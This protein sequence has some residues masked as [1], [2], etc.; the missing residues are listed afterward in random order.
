MAG[1]LRVMSLLKALPI[2]ALL[3]CPL[4]VTAEEPA[5]AAVA[6]TTEATTTEVP[7]EAIMAVITTAISEGVP[8]FND[9]DHQGCADR[10][11]AG[12]ERLAGFGAEA[13][14]PWHHHQVT[15][16]L[17]D[18]EASATDRAWQIRRVF[19]AI[20]LDLQFV[21]R[22]EASLPEGFPEPGPVGQVVRKDYPSYRMAT[23]EGRA[24][25]WTLFRHIKANDIPMTA[26]V[27]MA[28]TD[29][30]QQMMGFM[31]ESVRQGTLGEQDGVEVIEVPPSS[32]I[33][34]TLRGERR[35]QILVDAQAVIEAWA[36]AN[37][38]TL[39]DE[40]RLFGYSSPMIPRNQRY[41]EVQ[42]A[43]A[44]ST[45]EAAVPASSTDAF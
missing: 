32:V 44:G 36:Q 1:K 34:M 19:D 23:S 4:F 38:V 25:F 41:W 5:A 20:G 42:V 26:P 22:Q 18:L 29:N 9:G 28:A 15:T 6:D 30:G 21:P 43:I 27:E 45:S 3:A 31:Y 16:A 33:S 12:L 10:Y 39:S 24:A 17:A 11:Q 35:D 2:A 7:A 37:N 8:L 40:W 13:L 14:R